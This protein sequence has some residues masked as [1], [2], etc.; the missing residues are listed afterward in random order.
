MSTS[1]TFSLSDF[2]YELPE[3]RIAQKPADPRDHS[4]LLVYN[5]KDRSIKDDVFLHLPEYLPENSVLVINNS[6][7]EKARLLFGK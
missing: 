4:R 2:D 7:V 6:R 1:R 5:R 3:S